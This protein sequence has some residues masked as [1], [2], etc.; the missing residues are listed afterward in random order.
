MSPVQIKKMRSKFELTQAQMAVALGVGTL[1]LSQYEIGF[2]K[3][4]GSVLLLMALLDSLPLKKALAL[5]DDLT[6]VAVKL[7]A[8]NR[9]KTE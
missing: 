3:P 8:K 4:G 1:T 2:R 5:I 9:G 6:G 7:E